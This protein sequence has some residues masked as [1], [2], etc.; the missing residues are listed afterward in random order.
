MCVLSGFALAKRGGQTELQDPR[1]VS[2]CLC[3]KSQDGFPAEEASKRGYEGGEGIPG[4]R[5][6]VG[7]G[8]EA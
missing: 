5:Y 8:W 3:L 4:Q 7:K 2:A 1:G 6:G